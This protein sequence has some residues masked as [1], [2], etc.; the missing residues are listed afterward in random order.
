[1]ALTRRGR[2]RKALAQPFPEA[3]RDLLA[4]NVAHWR[5]LSGHERERLEGLIRLLLVDK[6]W[7]A[8]QGFELTDEIRVV[9][10]AMAGL[11]ILGAAD[12]S[13]RL[14]PP[15]VVTPEQCAFA[16]ET[17]EECLTLATG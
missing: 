8:S 1:M 3:W 5:T 16:L 11:L 15:L 7:E 4:D 9:I 10:S 2:R 12:N 6:L 13:L 17:L 14:C